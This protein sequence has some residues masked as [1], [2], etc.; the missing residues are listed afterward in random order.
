MCYRLILIAIVILPNVAHSAEW[1]GLTHHP[2]P[3]PDGKHVL[4]QSVSED[5]TPIRMITRRRR[6]NTH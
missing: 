2:L 1:T 6:A 3:S 4:S 5:T